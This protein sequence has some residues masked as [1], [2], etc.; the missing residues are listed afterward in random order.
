MHVGM[1]KSIPENL[2]Q[3]NLYAV[4]RQFFQI[5][6]GFLQAIDL[7]NGN[8]IHPFHHND[9]G[10]AVIPEYFRHDQGF[11]IGKITTQLAVIG[12]FAHQVK[13][14]VKGFVELVNHSRQA[15]ALAVFPEFFPQSRKNIHQFDVTTDPLLH[16]RAQYLDGNLMPVMQFR[17]MN[18]CNGSGCNRDSV[19]RCE[20]LFRRRA[21]I[22]G[23]LLDGYIGIERWNPVLKF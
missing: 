14:I 4:I 16:F 6:S 12:R 3:K 9:I 17:K 11:G 5:E 13:F 2:R 8:A 10:R 18:L 23:Y 15:Q 21:K 1:K 22:P 20:Q 19:K 7:R